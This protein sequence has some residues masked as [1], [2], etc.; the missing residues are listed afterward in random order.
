MAPLAQGSRKITTWRTWFL[1]SILYQS[2]AKSHISK[3]WFMSLVLDSQLV[4]YYQ[5]YP[6]WAI[7]VTISYLSTLHPWESYLTFAML[8]IFYSENGSSNNI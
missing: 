5:K 4:G 1:D 6:S 8:S 7:N 2:V 3:S